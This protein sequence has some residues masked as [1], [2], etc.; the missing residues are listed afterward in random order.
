MLG[1]A[2]EALNDWSFEKH[3]AQLFVEETKGL[4]RIRFANLDHVDGVNSGD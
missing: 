4:V 1:G 2:V 3:G